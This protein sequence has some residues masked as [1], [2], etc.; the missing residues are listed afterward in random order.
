V[1]LDP[2]DGRVIDGPRAPGELGFAVLPPGDIIAYQPVADDPDTFFALRDLAEGLQP[3]V[4]HWFLTGA[5]LSAAARADVHLF[6]DAW[7][8]TGRQDQ[9][10]YYLAASRDFEKWLE[11]RVLEPE[12]AK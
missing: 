2:Y 9:R 11:A 10:P 8:R 3:R 5:A 1:A 12:N 6:A 4:W 7:R